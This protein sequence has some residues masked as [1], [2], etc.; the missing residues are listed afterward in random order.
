MTASSDNRKPVDIVVASAGTGKTFRLV[1]EIGKAIASGAAPG[2]ILATTFTN[3]AAAELVERARSKLIGEGHW[4][5]SAGLLSARV[6]TVNSVFGRIVGDFALNAGRSPVTDV[7]PEQRQGRVFA[8]AAEDAIARRAGEMIPIAQRLDIEDWTDHVWELAG[9]VRQNDIDPSGLEDHAERSLNGYRAILPPPTNETGDTLDAR[10]RDALAE[11]RDALKNSSDPTRTTAAVKER[12]DEAAAV[13]ATGRD[14]PWSRWAALAKLKPAKKSVDLVQPVVGRAMAHAAHPRLHADLKAYIRGIYRTAAEALALYAEYKDAHGLVDFIDQEHLAL[15]LLDDPAVAERLRE[16]LSR[17]FVDEFQDTSPIQLALFLKVSQV[18]ERSFWVGDPKQAIF[19]FRGA[20][21]DLILR[22]ARTIVPESGGRGEL[23]PTSYRARPGL[24]DFTNRAFGPAFETLGFKPGDTRIEECHRGD[25]DG[26]TA[27]IEVWGIAGDTVAVAMTVLAEKIRSVLDDAAAHPVEDKELGTM[28]AIRGSDIAVLCRTNAHCEDVADELAVS[29]VRVSIARPGLLE[30]PE[31]VL[32]MAALR[33]LVDPGDTLAI[34]EIAHLY[35]DAK[36]QP[37]WFAHSLSED[38]I[39]SLAS[40]LPVF[41]A[42]D[43][44]RAELAALT[45][46]EALEVAIT[47]SGI[48]DR[49]GAWHNA[50]DRIGNLDALRAFAVQYVDEARTV[51]SAATAAGLVA[52]LGDSAG[53]DNELP[54]TT[55]PDAVNVSSYHRAKGLEWPMVVLFDLDRIRRAPSAFEFNVESGGDF[56]VWRPLKDRWVR[57]WPWPYG[58]QTKNVHIDASASATDEHRRAEQRE[59]AETVRLLYVGITR[60]RDYLVLAPRDF[61]KKGLRLSW[62]DLL[63]DKDK[64]PILAF[65]RTGADLAV[66]AG[67]T[68]VPVRFSETRAVDRELRVEEPDTAWRMPEAQEKPERPPYRIA[69]S[70]LEPSGAASA[71]VVSRIELGARIPIAGSPDMTALGEAVHAFLAFDRPGQ[72]PDERRDRAAATLERW[73]TGGLRPEHLVEMSDRLFAHIETEFPG[74]TICAEVPVFGRRY[75]QRLAGRIDLLLT[76]GARAVV[77]DHKSYPGAFD[78]W[79]AMA[80]GYA[81]QLALYAS[82]VRGAA[83]SAE[84]ETWV[85]MPVVGQLIQVRAVV[86]GWS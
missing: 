39:G 82:V 65:S 52:W 45:P 16:T 36:D 68:T 76:N 17:V 70:A 6:G 84:V 35:D 83:G 8:I 48:L 27:P 71:E 81:A 1:E 43:D 80:L 64:Q 50:L 60:A 18:A 55:D 53:L 66:T 20:D 33:Y 46:S 78:T 67:G 34:A 25:G 56:D 62:L 31:A 13:L 77:I 12:V 42:L 24:V 10:L 15:G 63:V 19:G 58:R 37:S 11:V 85:H 4:D 69:P 28:R 61:G 75:G 51:R 54:P 3:K 14:L 22:A 74:M 7:I 86:E 29:G 49:I 59:R 32:A 47:A 5:Q 73:G 79:E 40:E 30:T 21:P 41:A 38:G 26:Q 9:I 23:L 2:S 57:F 44:R 72:D